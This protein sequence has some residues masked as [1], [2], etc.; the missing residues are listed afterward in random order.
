MN[1]Q[2]RTIFNQLLEIIP[3]SSFNKLVGQHN[4]DRY[5]KHF[6]CWQHMITMLYAQAT[7][8]DSL[9]ELELWLKLHN[10]RRYH[11]WLTSASRNTIANA[12]NN[13]SYEIYEK[14]FYELLNKCKQLDYKRQFK[15]KNELYSL[16]AS[17]IDLCLSMFSW[18]QYRTRKWALKLHL[19]LNNKSVLPEFINITEWKVHEI[20][21]ARKIELPKWSILAID[22]WYIDYKWFEELSIKWIYF[23]TRSKSNMDY[24][25]TKE[26]IVNESNI[27]SDQEIEVFNW[28][29]ISKKKKVIFRLIKYYDT[30]QKKFYTFITN[31]YRLSA[32]TM[33]WIYKS[34]WDIEL[35]FKW[36]KQNLKI[37]SFLWTSKNAVMSQIWIAMIYYLIVY[38]IKHKTKLKL[39]LLEFTRIIKELL[40]SRISLIDAL[41]IPFR[42]IYLIKNKWD[43]WQLSLF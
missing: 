28:D 35:F 16:D 29:K 13:R 30:I 32:K 11:L 10:D 7:G 39:S 25:V 33:A 38:Y 14:L 12:N 21:I 23:I 3:K 43:P 20:N 22:R 1:N 8:K 42:E 34:R 36:I 6:T 9:R 2:I 27:I 26:N 31:N 5:V 15:F 37:K 24:I 41:W 40:M 4:G 19:L 18:A 17:V